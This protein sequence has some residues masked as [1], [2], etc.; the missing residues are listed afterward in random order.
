MRSVYDVSVDVEF[1]QI[2][3]GVDED[4]EVRH[5]SRRFLGEQERVDGA[6]VGNEIQ[7]AAPLLAGFTCAVMRVAGR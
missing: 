7:I 5:R 1:V 6:A 3:V 2:T 4:L